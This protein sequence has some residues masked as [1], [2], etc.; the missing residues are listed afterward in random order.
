M[1]KPTKAEVDELAAWMV[2]KAV[3][4][5]PRVLPWPKMSKANKD[6]IR[7]VAR[8]FLLKPPPVLLLRFLCL[9]EFPTRAKP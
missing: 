3:A 9:Q 7:F 1:K 5:E 6:R 2:A 8:A 4:H